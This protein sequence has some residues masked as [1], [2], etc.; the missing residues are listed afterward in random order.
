MFKFETKLAA[1]VP[2]YLQ[3]CSYRYIFKVKLIGYVLKC[4]WHALCVKYLI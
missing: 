1:F 2:I 3:N 4:W